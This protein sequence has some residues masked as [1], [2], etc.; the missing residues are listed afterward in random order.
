MSPRHDLDARLWGGLQGDLFLLE[1]ATYQKCRTDRQL[2]EPEASS[3][4]RQAD[5]WMAYFNKQVVS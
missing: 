5:Q 4:H 1:P 3:G 2:A